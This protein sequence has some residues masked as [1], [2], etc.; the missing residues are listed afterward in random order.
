LLFCGL[1]CLKDWLFRDFLI[2]LIWILGDLWAF[3]I[4][5]LIL[6]SVTYPDYY[7]TAAEIDVM[8]N[9]G[10]Y[11][12]VNGFTNNAEKNII[13]LFW[14]KIDDVWKVVFWHSFVLN[15]E[16]DLPSSSDEVN[17]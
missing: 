8:L 13:G 3:S 1:Y 6:M 9:D 14:R 12:T 15:K 4:V 10:N 5:I 11:W 16:I 17:I 2:C 7:P